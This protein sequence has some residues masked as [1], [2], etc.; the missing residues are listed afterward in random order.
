MSSKVGKKSKKHK[1]SKDISDPVD[2]LLCGDVS[3]VIIA[4]KDYGDIGYLSEEE[5][6]VI[7]DGHVL[8]GC[9]H[10][11]VFSWGGVCKKCFM[12]GQSSYR[13]RGIDEGFDIIDD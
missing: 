8:C 6:K 5:K 4:G 11:D 1:N 9:G 10:R 7:D 13:V 12:K 2:A 3:Y